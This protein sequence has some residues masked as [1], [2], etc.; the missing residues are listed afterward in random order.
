MKGQKKKKK[1]K[2]YFKDKLSFILKIGL[3]LFWSLEYAFHYTQTKNITKIDS[4]H[5]KFSRTGIKPLI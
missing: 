1:S 5:F 2:P 3:T 4:G